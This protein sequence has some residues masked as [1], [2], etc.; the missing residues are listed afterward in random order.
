MDTSMGIKLTLI[1]H[2]RKD[3]IGFLGCAGDEAFWCGNAMLVHDFHTDV[4]CK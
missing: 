3:V 1:H 4:F 2:G